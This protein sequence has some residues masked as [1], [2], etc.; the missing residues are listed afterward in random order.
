MISGS[1]ST[2]KDQRDQ[3]ASKRVKRWSGRI[4]EDGGS[5]DVGTKDRGIWKDKENSRG[6]S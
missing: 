1:E 6:R 2:Q 3:R 5:K 4:K